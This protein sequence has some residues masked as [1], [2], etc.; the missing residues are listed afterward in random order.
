MQDVTHPSYGRVKV[1]GKQLQL[2]HGR[3]H[4]AALMAVCAK[5]RIPAFNITKFEFL[6]PPAQYRHMANEVRSAPPLLG[7]HTSEVLRK[8]LALS[9]EEISR[10]QRDKVIQ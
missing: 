9:E 8:E 10:L 5:G 4:A 6:G 2:A 1:T 3:S 7:E